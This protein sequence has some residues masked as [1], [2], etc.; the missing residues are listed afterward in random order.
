VIDL[1]LQVNQVR[2]TTL[3]LVTHDPELAALAS[4]RLALRD[5]RIDRE[6]SQ[7]EPTVQAR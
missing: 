4:V 2:K 1:L 6:R 3:V 7:L 5:G